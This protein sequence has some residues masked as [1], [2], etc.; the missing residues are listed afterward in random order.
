MK[1]IFVYK[2]K[3]VGGLSIKAL[4]KSLKNSEVASSY[5]INTISAEELTYSEWESEC[6]LFVMPGGR[7]VPYHEALKGEANGK[8]KRY[9][10]GGGRYLGICAGAYYASNHVVFEKN[11]EHEV[12]EP[13][14]LSFFPGNAIGT[15]YK[16]KPFSYQGHESAHPALIKGDEDALY[17]Y[18]N[19]GCYFEDPEAHQPQVE[20]L[21]RY[22]NAIYHNVAAVVLCNVGEGK[23]LL[24]GV[25]FEVSPSYFT[26]EKKL[27]LRLAPDEE[28]RQRFFDSLLVR[29]LK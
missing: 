28:K 18:Y 22:Q 13:R 3:G 6:A 25:H 8:I 12:V 2:D 1:T 15:L 21:A 4:L 29:T 9:I 27:H 19:G 17:T 26:N 7:D 10:E 24:S 23:A 16:D 20:V 14:E 5:L 11:L